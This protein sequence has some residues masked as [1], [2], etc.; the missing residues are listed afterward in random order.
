MDTIINA[1]AAQGLPGITIAG[2]GFAVFTLYKRNESLNDTLRDITEK[3]AVATGAATSA[4]SRLSD[5]LAVRK[6]G[7]Q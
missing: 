1:L 4:I 2:L 6:E 3:Y 5:M 7:G